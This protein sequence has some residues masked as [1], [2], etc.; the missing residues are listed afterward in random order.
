MNYYSKFGRNIE[1]IY[2]K[3]FPKIINNS[4]VNILKTYKNSKINPF[5]YLNKNGEAPKKKDEDIFQKIKP[6]KFYKNLSRSEEEIKKDRKIYLKKIYNRNSFYNN[7]KY[8]NQIKIER[9]KRAKKILE[10]RKKL[11]NPDPSRYNPN[12]NYLY[13]SVKSC[14]FGKEHNKSV[15]LNKNILNYENEIYKTNYLIKKK[16]NLFKIKNFIKKSSITNNNIKFIK[17]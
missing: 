8:E 17:K 12:Y 16:K 5:T 15:N 2:L 9:I 11:Y 1:K 3:K 6:E 4:N 13:V 7:E 14:V 10:Q